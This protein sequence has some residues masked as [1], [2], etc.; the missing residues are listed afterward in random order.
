MPPSAG[1]PGGILR[2]LGYR[3]YFVLACAVGGLSFVGFAAVALLHYALF[4]DGEKAALVWIRAFGFVMTRFLFWKVEVEDIETLHATQP[5][6]VVGNHQSNLDIATWATFFPARSVAVGKKEILKIPVFGWLWKVSKHI[7]IDRSNAAAARES[8]RAAAAR[9]RAENL[10]VWVLPEGHR[11][12]KPEML[13]FKKGA[14][15][16][17]IA[18]QVPVVPFATSPMWTVLDARRWM[19]RP[20]VVRVRFLPPIPTAGMT[21]DDADRLSF[22]AREAIEG[23]RQDFLKTAGPRIG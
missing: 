20:G 17:A 10:S 4:R 22:A 13:P 9:I 3:A 19:V 15:H 23:A 21:D 12:A 14:F 7:L 5:A 6:V 8:L 2:R 1:G 11:N 18:A 16:L